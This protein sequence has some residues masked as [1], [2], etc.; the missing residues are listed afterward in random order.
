MLD[1]FVKQR[2]PRHHILNYS[3]QFTNGADMK[4][5]LSFYVVKN[6]LDQ[7]SQKCHICGQSI[8]FNQI[9]EPVLSHDFENKMKKKD[10]KTHVNHAECA[11]GAR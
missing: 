11:N 9:V 6:L 5:D 8:R 2:S 7:N 10:S 4:K 1:I 3:E